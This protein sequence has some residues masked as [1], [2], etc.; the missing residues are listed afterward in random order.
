MNPFRRGAFA[1]VVVVALMGGIAQAWDPASASAGGLEWVRQFRFQR[2]CWTQGVA[3]DGSGVYVVGE[4]FRSGG[5][6]VGGFLTKYDLD[7]T[8]LWSRTHL[9]S[10]GDPVFAVAAGPSGVYVVVAIHHAHSVR[11]RLRRYQQDGDLAWTLSFDRET[12]P[13]GLAV[14]G[15]GAYIVGRVARHVRN[16]SKARS[17]SFAMKISAAG[18]QVWSDRFGLQSDASA[19]SVDSRGFS[20]VGLAADGLWGHAS[21]GGT[22]AY[23][24][25]F[26]TSGKPLWTRQFGTADN[27]EATAVA[28]DA[29]GEYVAGTT[30]LAPQTSFVRK[31]DASGHS[32]WHHSISTAF[33]LTTVN[34]A[35][36]AT[37]GS[38]VALAI[39]EEDL[40]GAVETSDGLVR[41]YDADGLVTGTQHVGTDDAD[42][43]AGAVSS[44]GDIYVAG[45]TIGSFPGYPV[46]HEADAF[47]ARIP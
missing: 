47:V 16:A 45:T 25:R 28:G 8:R 11:F 44:E 36:P 5:D 39:S 15:S 32:V 1:I 41:T 43:L 30:G 7:G 20:V 46:T 23:I 3:V 2:G 18:K 24:R 31:F 29:T 38:G 4:T 40:A 37:S 14:D 21:A 9:G 17:L 33:P 22:D 42:E 13:Q 35:T 6:G 27:D 26:S 34:S 10:A 12:F 19:I